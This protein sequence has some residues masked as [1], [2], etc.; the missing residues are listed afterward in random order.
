[1][2]HVFISYVREDS[3]KVNLLFE[4]L[5]SYGIDI[6]LDRNSITPGVR[7]KRAIRDA[8]QNGAFFI[9]CFS[10]EY[11]NKTKSYM[12]EEIITAIEELRKR[13]IDNIWFIP[14][15]LDNCDVADYDIGAGETLKSIQHIE[16]FENWN[17]GI[18]KIVS[19]VKKKP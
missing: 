17:E 6:W 3:D 1:M 2:S 19:V 9:A 16:L 7:W 11:N 12:N 18:K 5:Q 15:L 4:D 14:V 10:S 8:I 13:S